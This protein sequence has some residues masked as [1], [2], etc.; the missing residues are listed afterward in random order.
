MPEVVSL[1]IYEDEDCNDYLSPSSRQ[2]LR[3]AINLKTLIDKLIPTTISSES[4][5]GEDSIILNDYAINAVYMAA[6]GEGS[7]KGSSAKRYQAALIFCLLKV[8]GWYG[9]LMEN[10]LSN[11]DLY[12]ARM[13]AAEKIASIL[14]DRETDDK[15]LFLSMLCHRYSINLNDEDADPEN[16]LELAVDMHSTTII[17]SSGYQ[18]CIKWLWRGWIVQ[19]N[20]DPTEY[21]LFRGISRDGMAYHFD[22]GRIKTPLYQNILEIFFSL[23]YLFVFTIIVNTDTDAL[24]LNFWEV[25]YYLFTIAFVLDELTKFSHIGLNYIQFSNAF[26]DS[27]YALVLGSLVIRLA[28]IYAKTPESNEKLNIMS[29]RILSLAAP[30]MWTRLLL[31]LDVYQFVGN[32]I[33]VIK[34][35]MKESIIFFVMLTFI[36]IG[37]LQAFLGLDQADGKREL[38]KIVI[39]SLLRTILSGPNFDTISRFASPYGSILYYAFAIIVILILL[40]ILIALYAQAYSDVVENATDEYLA[41]YSSKILKYIRAPDAKIFC[42]PLNLVEIVF[43]EIPLSWW[44]RKTVYDEI[45]DKVMIILYAPVLAY[46][47]SYESKEAQRVVYNRSMRVAD[48]ANEIDTEWNLADGFDTDEDHSARVNDSIIRQR[49][50]EQEDPLFS[51]NFDVWKKS[52]E[53]LTPPIQRSKDVCVPWKEYKIYDKLDKLGKMVESLVNENKELVKRIDKMSVK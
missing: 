37:F 27:M 44:V 52:L 48:D 20:H 3:I 24:H 36:L 7:G 19:S 47:S 53:N 39:Q 4:I 42:P 13:I 21:V 14:I 32:M 6:G 49:R 9:S 2:V 46:I 34:K 10:E 43:L 11:N 5:I 25:V 50:A 12:S 22:P 1:P 40:N 8:A 41:Q 33:V 38:T 35:M 17:G 51:K 16:A 26:N 31:F 18:R 30:F 28:G 15:Y 23:L 45:C 29:Y